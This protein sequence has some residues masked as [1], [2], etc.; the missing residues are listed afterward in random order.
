MRKETELEFLGNY[1][2]KAK[3]TA[4]NI[5]ENLPK[6]ETSREV[7]T[8][9]KYLKL[10]PFSEMSNTW[11]PRK[12]LTNMYGISP[13]LNRLADKISYMINK[14][15]SA[16][17]EVMVI[18]IA[19]GRIKTLRKIPSKEALRNALRSGYKKQPELIGKGHFRWDHRAYTLNNY[20]LEQ[21]KSYFKI[22]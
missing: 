7:N 18:K 4:D 16:D 22:N 10:I 11:N 13:T 9:G 5:R 3:Q 6:M 17:V 8:F 14:G 1:H 12:L 21:L 20:E 2:K 19:T 15:R